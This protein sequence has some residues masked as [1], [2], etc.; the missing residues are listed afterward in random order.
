MSEIFQRV[1]GVFNRNN[2]RS[3]PTTP[4]TVVNPYDKRKSKRNRTDEYDDDDNTDDDDFEDIEGDDRSQET[5]PRRQA[6]GTQ[7]L[8]NEDRPLIL[9]NPN[10]N[11]TPLRNISNGNQSNLPNNINTNINPPVNFNNA[12]INNSTLPPLAPF[13]PRTNE[14]T[15]RVPL[16][17]TPEQSLDGLHS[18]TTPNRP[19]INRIPQP[20]LRRSLSPLIYRE[21]PP[22]RISPHSTLIGLPTNLN[23]QLHNPSSRPVRSSF[24]QRSN[25]P[26][27]SFQSRNHF[28]NYEYDYPIEDIIID[29]N[30]PSS[31]AM[32]INQ[33][34]EQDRVGSSHHIECR[35][36]RNTPQHGLRHIR[37]IPNQ[38]YSYSY[39]Q[40]QLIINEIPQVNY[41][42]P[43]YD[44][45]CIPIPIN[46]YI[47][48]SL[49]NDP[50]QNY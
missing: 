25:R 32:K 10:N 46:H 24:T 50:M 34:V 47:A 15:S 19:P 1:R 39:N 29:K 5:Q 23:R 18:R 48:H 43:Q 22:L 4:D 36:V 41:Y 44:L 9:S 13:Q 7:Q 49:P 31:I 27:S 6:N 20:T 2:R 33:A 38:N 30:I 11:N 35:L 16:N 26:H 14:P 8:L 28:S 3:E 42:Y 17:S 40:P 12:P 21:R 37:E 45:N